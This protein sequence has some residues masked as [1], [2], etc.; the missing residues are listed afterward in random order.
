ME[1]AHFVDKE[2]HTSIKNWWVIMLLGIAFILLSLIVFA[3]PV[4]S[5][6]ALSIFFALGILS[7]GIFQ[8]AF[9]I[10]NRNKVEGWG[11]QLTLGI[12]EISIGLILVFKMNITMAILPLYIGFWLLFRAFALMG[13]SFEL[14]SYKIP[15]WGYYL[16]LGILL[17]IFSWIIILNP[18]LGGISII[19]WTGIALLTAGI[20]HIILSVKLKKINKRI[21]KFEDTI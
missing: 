7:S 13:F 11:W 17:A 5:Y 8:F 1:K 3:N 18:L 6:V 21:I 12:M 4:K 2:I 20:T 9:A 15:N 10:G 19:T 16:F 14:K